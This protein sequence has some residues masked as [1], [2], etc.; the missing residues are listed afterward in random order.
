MPQTC[1]SY[2]MECCVGNS[3]WPHANG[4]MPHAVGNSLWPHATGCMPH[5]T[6]TTPR[7]PGVFAC[8]P[9][10][11][12]TTPRV[13]GVFAGVLCAE[14]GAAPAATPWS[15]PSWAPSNTQ[16]RPPGVTATT[17]GARGGLLEGDPGR[18][19]AGGTSATRAGVVAGVLAGVLAGVMGAM[20]GTALGAVLGAVAVPLAGVF[21]PAGGGTALA[22]V[23]AP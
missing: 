5:A 1:A 3:L 23:R 21:A 20:L 16:A 17:G 13:P 6:Q 9:H 8:M 18:S 4:C 14:S 15:A 22:G 10:A 7:V 19:S 11:T 2:V 12:Q